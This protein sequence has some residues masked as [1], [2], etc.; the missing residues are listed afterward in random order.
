MLRSQTLQA[1]WSGQLKPR[2]VVIGG[3]VHGAAALRI[4]ALNNIPA[5]LIER[6]DFAAETSSRSSKM[7]HGGLRYLENFDIRQVREGIIARDLLFRDYAHLCQP[8]RFLIPIKRG[9]LWQR[10]KLGAALKF[11]DFM[12]SKPE[13]RHHWITREKLTG[14]AFNNQNEQIDGCFEYFD[15]LMQDAR[16]VTENIVDACAR[17]ASALNYLEVKVIDFSSQ[18]AKIECLDKITNSNFSFEAE[19]VINC[20]GPWVAQLG[21]A[22]FED[23]QKR[24]RYSRGVHLIFETKWKDAALFLPLPGKSRYYFVWPHPAGTMVGTS[25]LEV[26]QAE[27]DP[28]PL[29]SEIDEILD[30]CAR[31]LPN[32]D[33]NRDTLIYAFAGVRTL[34]IRSQTSSTAQISRRHIWQE[35]DRA[36]CLLGGK[37]TTA[38]QTSLEAVQLANKRLGLKAL[39]L[40]DLSGIAL[41]GSG[42]PAQFERMIEQLCSAGLSKSHALRVVKNYGLN[43]QD[44]LTNPQFCQ[45]LT[46]NLL[47]G[48]LE[49]SYQREQAIKVEDFL[50]RRLNLELMPGHGLDELNY[51]ADFLGGKSINQ[52]TITQQVSAYRARVAQVLSILRN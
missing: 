36:A 5:L 47:Y 27:F 41:S 24:L 19:Y 21:C 38:N 48:E 40:K 49:I 18:F 22:Q 6:S 30:R 51:I 28:L 13:L 14:P 29:K 35:F 32:M 15:G 17:G 50:S 44:F 26:E 25:E 2:V 52:N 23:I 4:C 20:A 31:D 42:P 8:Q 16:I 7:A 9:D 45:P 46:P 34:P 33:L 43:A 37:F 1:L 39:A 3:G 10:I 12:S 11:Y